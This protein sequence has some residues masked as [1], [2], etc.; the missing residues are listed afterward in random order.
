MVIYVIIGVI[1][2]REKNRFVASVMCGVLLHLHWNCL[3]NTITNYTGLTP[4]K[5]TKNKKKRFMI[6]TLLWFSLMS[7]LLIIVSHKRF[8]ST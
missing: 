6:V 1:N 3:K 8:C 7:V 2:N 4:A 5:Q